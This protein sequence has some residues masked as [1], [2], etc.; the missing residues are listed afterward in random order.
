MMITLSYSTEL[1]PQRRTTLLNPNQMLIHDGGRIEGERTSAAAGLE[2]AGGIEKARRGN[3]C[4]CMINVSGM[5]VAVCI[6][7]GSTRY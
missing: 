4:P 5:Q 1:S 6:C 7:E 3:M 2:I